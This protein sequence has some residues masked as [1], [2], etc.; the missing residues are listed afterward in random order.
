MGRPTDNP[1]P[2]QAAVRLDQEAKDILDAYCKQESV[3]VMEAIRRGVKR[4][5]A[6]TEMEEKRGVQPDKNTWEYTLKLDNESK[7]ILE[8]YSRQEAVPLSEGARRGIQC[9][10]IHLK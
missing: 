5:K 10:K 9:L 2:Y 4:L 3:S 8:Q 7:E 6:D 1:K